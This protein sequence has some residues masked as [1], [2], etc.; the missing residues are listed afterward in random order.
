MLCLSGASF[1]LLLHTTFFSHHMIRGIVDAG[2]GG[3]CFFLL[4]YLRAPLP[5]R[6]QRFAVVFP[7]AWP[8]HCTAFEQPPAPTQRL[9]FREVSGVEVMNPSITRTRFRVEILNTRSRCRRW[10]LQQY[11]R[12][13]CTTQELLLAALLLALFVVVLQRF[14][15][16]L[17][18]PPASDKDRTQHAAAL[19]VLPGVHVLRSCKWVVCSTAAGRGNPPSTLGRCCMF[20]YVLSSL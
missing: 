18:P 15:R 6:Q 1:L 7:L 17:T 2:Y 9:M 16:L 4:L 14:R 5:V 19:S 20:V 13:L 8:T 3:L 12:E 10:S 11:S